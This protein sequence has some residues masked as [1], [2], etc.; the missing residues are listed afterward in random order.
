[1]CFIQPQCGGY[2]LLF[3]FIVLF[4]HLLENCSFLMTD[5]TGVVL[6]ESGGGEDLEGVKGRETVIRM[7]CMGKC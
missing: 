7:Y 2:I 5:K 6:D 3:Y 1:M 4:C